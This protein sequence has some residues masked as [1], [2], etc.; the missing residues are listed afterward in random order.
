MRD[1]KTMTR[2]IEATTSDEAFKLVAE[3]VQKHPDVMFYG[4]FKFF[5]TKLNDNVVYRMYLGAPSGLHK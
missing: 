5:P 1:H 3:Y 4:P 2:D